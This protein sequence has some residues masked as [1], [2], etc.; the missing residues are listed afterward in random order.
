MKGDTLNR[1]LLDFD[2]NVQA[3]AICKIRR[4]FR[5]IFPAVDRIEIHYVLKGTLHLS[6]SGSAPL[7]CG[8]GGVVIVPMGASQS[9]GADENA[10]HD[11]AAE[12]HCSTIED[13]FLLFDAANAETADLILVCGAARETLGGP[14]GVL[15]NVSA[16]IVQKFCERPVDDSTFAVMLDE[17]TCPGLGTRA[18]LGALMK[19]CLLKALRCNIGEAEL[20][21]PQLYKAVAA[22]LANPAAAFDVAALA[23]RAGMSRS[24]F[25]SEFLAAFAMTPMEFVRKVRMHHGAELLRHTAIPIKAIAHR[26]GFA[27]RS[28]FS[29]AFH[30][31]FGTDPR[32]FRRAANGL[33]TLNGA[34]KGSAFQGCPAAATL[35]AALQSLEF[36]SQKGAK[37]G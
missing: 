14:L 26:V 9:I 35:P 22:V 29:A 36:M 4:G 13:G 10:H 23:S 17:I 31:A 7:I 28:H 19:I 27:S 2:V 3:L 32:S 1:L 37:H 25:A 15:S 5:L 33:S 11:L 18:V 20:R 24:T 6:A 12:K 34:S 16:P 30:R 21:A 8:P